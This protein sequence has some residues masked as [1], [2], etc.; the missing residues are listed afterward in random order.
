MIEERGHVGGDEIF[1]LAEA[2]DD[3]RSITRGDDLV[4]F[5][6]RDHHQ[7]EDAGEFFHRFTHRFLQLQSRSLLLSM[8]FPT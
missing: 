2:D 8:A 3:G 5:V 6:D 7:R 1:V 4:R